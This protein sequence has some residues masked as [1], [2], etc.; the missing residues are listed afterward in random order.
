MDK[1]KVNCFKCKYYAT[2]WQPGYPRSCR[3]YG[4]KGTQMPSLTV[5]ATTGEE[6]NA[7][8]EK[9]GKKN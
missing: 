5:V 8:E 3:F 9:R 6:C 1:K 2:T 4:F 7:F